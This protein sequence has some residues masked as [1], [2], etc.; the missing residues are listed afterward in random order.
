MGF[1]I[2]TESLEKKICGRYIFEAKEEA[3]DFVKA[4]EEKAEKKGTGLS[5]RIISQEE[6]E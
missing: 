5:Y 2:V 4:R 1:H 6:T 3:E